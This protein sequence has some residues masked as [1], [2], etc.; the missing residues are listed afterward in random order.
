M[1]VILENK[2]DCSHANLGYA[3]SEERAQECI[4][5]ATGFRKKRPDL[6]CFI[7]YKLAKVLI[8][9]ANTNKN[10]KDYIVNTPPLT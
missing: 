3:K 7:G 5:G 6:K 4:S 9:V 1:G 2:A 10:T 8:Y